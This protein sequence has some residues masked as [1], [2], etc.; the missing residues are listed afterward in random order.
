M[1]T[2]SG[3]QN[4]TWST[5]ATLP[6][7]SIVP[8]SSQVYTV[9]GSAFQV[10]KGERTVSITVSEC[11]GLSEWELEN[12]MRIYPTPTK[13]KLTLEIFSDAELVLVN[14][15]GNIFLKK[16]CKAGIHELNMEGFQAGMYIL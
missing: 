10:C 1:L 5:G 6:T 8:M 4:Y 9:V 12:R 14:G 3:A 16:H 2:V 7:I 15:F 11:V 13:G